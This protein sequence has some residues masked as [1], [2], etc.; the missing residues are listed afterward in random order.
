MSWK[1]L[2]VVL[3]IKELHQEAS[4]TAIIKAQWL[5]WL[6]MWIDWIRKAYKNGFKQV[7]YC[8][9]EERLSKNEMDE[10]VKR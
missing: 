9:E 8:K 7:V 3:E 1:V 5:K 10:G 2:K 4:I 6:R